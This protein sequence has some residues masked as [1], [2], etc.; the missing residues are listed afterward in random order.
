M[1]P[2]SIVFRI[3]NHWMLDVNQFIHLISLWTFLKAL[4]FEECIEAL[5]AEARDLIFSA[6][7]V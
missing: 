4:F 3:I 6:P 5:L 7:C 2:S 1:V